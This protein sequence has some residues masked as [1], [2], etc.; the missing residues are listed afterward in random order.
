MK[1]RGFT[2]LELLIAIGIFAIIGLASYHVLDTVSDTQVIMDERTQSLRQL[3]KTAVILK[4]DMLQLTDR[5]VRSEYGDMSPSLT[6]QG[7]Y[8]IELSHLG[9][10]NPAGAKRGDIQRVA[11]AIKDH[12]LI[13]YYW[14]VLDRAQDSTPQEQILLSGVDEIDVR[15][16]D[17]NKQWVEQWPLAIAKSN[18]EDT[19]K[20]FLPMAVE[21]VLKTKLYGDVRWL[22][23]IGDADEANQKSP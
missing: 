4:K 18:K 1:Q 2:L 3:Q 15:F 6:S 10:R 8:S 20:I 12:K 16:M 5:A 13:R 22:Y 11:Y 19:K 14:S 23:L 17:P 9:W 21:L 7:L